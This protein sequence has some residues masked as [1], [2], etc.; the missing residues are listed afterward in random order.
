ME[1]DEWK[2][3]LTPEEYKVMREKQT[4]APFSGKFLKTDRKGTYVCKACS[5]V[6]FSSDAKFDSGTGWP[7]FEELANRENV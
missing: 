7:S 6:L 2:N 1:N 3:K 4:E 5:N